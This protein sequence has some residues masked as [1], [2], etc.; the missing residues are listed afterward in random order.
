MHH[1]STTGRP[2]S[3]TLEMR[4]CYN[5][6]Y[7]ETLEGYQSQRILKRPGSSDLTHWRAKQ[8]KR[9]VNSC[10]RRWKTVV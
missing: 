10:I 8:Q 3:A 7:T 2:C 6:F 4:A 5:H 1:T 9:N